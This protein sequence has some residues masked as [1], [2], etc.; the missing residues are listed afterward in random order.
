HG[1]YTSRTC[2]SWSVASDSTTTVRNPA[3]TATMLRA[4][5]C[6][7]QLVRLKPDTTYSAVG[8]SR[9]GILDIR[10]LAGPK[11]SESRER[12]QRESVPPVGHRA[13]ALRTPIHSRVRL[14]AASVR[15]DVQQVQ[16]TP[17][18]CWSS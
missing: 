11:G 16:R 9:N 5:F 17:A 1:G 13:C 7:L 6:L 3:A 8:R 15:P 14:L 18:R 2:N 10:V 4:I 12:P